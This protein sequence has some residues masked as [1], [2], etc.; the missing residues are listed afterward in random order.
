MICDSCKQGKGNNG[1]VATGLEG[2]C[3][4]DRVAH[5]KEPDRQGIIK[6]V[7]DNRLSV[8]VQ[9]DDMPDGELDF[10]WSNKLMLIQT[11][12]KVEANVDKPHRCRNV[13]AYRTRLT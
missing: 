9:W 6:Q 10:Q 1:R 13:M 4:N 3:V 5:D 8:M 2:W 11:Y 12:K 7:E